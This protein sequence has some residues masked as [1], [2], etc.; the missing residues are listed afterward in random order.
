MIVKSTTVAY[1]TWVDDIRNAI[2]KLKEV[3]P[4]KKENPFIF[5]MPVYKTDM[6]NKIEWSPKFAIVWDYWVVLPN[7]CV[8]ISKQIIFPKSKKKRIMKKFSKNKNNWKEFRQEVWL[9][10]YVVA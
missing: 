9:M 10:H 8:T 3:I 4:E 2:K 6:L 5:W 1:W 7:R